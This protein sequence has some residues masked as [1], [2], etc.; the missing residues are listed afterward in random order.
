M[1]QHF[2]VYT[3]EQIVESP[4]GQIYRGAEARAACGVSTAVSK[5]QQGAAALPEG[6]AL[7]LRS[8]SYA[9][10]LRAGQ[11]FIYEME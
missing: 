4:T 11:R 10:K 1:F 8:H 9:R 7:Y 3:T 5:S 6:W 2:A